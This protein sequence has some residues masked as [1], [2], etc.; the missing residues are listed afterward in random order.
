MPELPEVETVV[1]QL[2]EVV[3]GH[4]V[5]AVDVI[6][7][8]L[9]AEPEDRFRASLL[10]AQIL[11][12][13]RRGKNLVF[14]ISGS[15]SRGSS[16]L[17]VVNLGMTG[18]LLFFPGQTGED[19]KLGSG[20]PSHPAVVLSLEPP[21]T[22]V[23]ADVRR[24][25]S[26]RVFSPEE[27]EVE[28]ARLGPEPLDPDLTGPQLHARLSCSRSPIRS[29]LLDQRRL[30]GMGNIY[31]SEALFRAGV[32]PYRAAQSLSRR[33]A[34]LLLDAIQAVLSEAILARGTTLR[35][36]RT[37]SGDYGGFGPALE[38]YGRDGEPCLRCNTPIE[39]VVFGNRS[40]F[41]CPKC[42]KGT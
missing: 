37:A 42:Q 16:L 18:Q 40:A 34:E 29:W 6:H 31:A 10:G 35:D 22:L 2:A 27:W 3:P 24:F 25:G 36:Y 11:S 33:E 26:L 17:L 9:L 15:G 39:R 13:G 1:R 32:H 5:S 23:Y 28:S 7:P 4:R 14:S 19:Y 30:A 38:A 20:A 8:D 41:F 21:A 12:V